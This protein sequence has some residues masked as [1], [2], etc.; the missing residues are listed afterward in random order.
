MKCMGRRR[1]VAYVAVLA[2]G[3]GGS[4]PVGPENFDQQAASKVEAMKKLADRMATD[5]NGPETLA[6]LEE[7]RLNTL[8][9]SK[10]ANQA[11]EILD[12]YRKRI[13]GKYKGEVAQQLQL[14]MAPLQAAAKRAK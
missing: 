4:Q 12:I 13:Q 10:H 7:F 2:L 5:P 8:D 11:E 6:A 14:E 3:C 9:P 1:F